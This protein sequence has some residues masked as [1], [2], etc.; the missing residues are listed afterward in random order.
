MAAL[1]PH[2]RELLRHTRQQIVQL[3][4]GNILVTPSYHLTPHAL[5]STTAHSV[6]HTVYLRLL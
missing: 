2:M 5:L 1:A 6:A 3:L 4:D